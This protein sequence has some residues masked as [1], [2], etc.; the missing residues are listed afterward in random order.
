MREASAAEL[1]R[2]L[3]RLIA[4]GAVRLE[5]DLKRLDHI[6]SPVAVEADSN[7]WIYGGVLVCAAVF[8]RIGLW[9]GVAAIAAALA[10]YFT[11]GRAYVR[12]RIKRRV[13]ERALADSE[14]WRKLWR[15]G[16]LALVEHATGAR[17]AAPDGNWMAL[18]RS[19]MPTTAETGGGV[20]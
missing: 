20:R 8:W 16:G 9:P 10:L 6:D 15:F 2:A 14:L 12:R 18:V 11:A 7:I 1:L 4:D 13:E 17:C 5:L 19:T 3:R